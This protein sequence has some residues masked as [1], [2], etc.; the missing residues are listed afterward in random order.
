M[1]LPSARGPLSAAVLDALRTGTDPPAPPPPGSRVELETVAPVSDDDLQLAL[2]MPTSCTTAASTT[3]THDLRV[4]PRPAAA[5]AA[6]RGR[7][8]GRAPRRT[9]TSC[10][11]GRGGRRRRGRA[12]LR[13][14]RRRRRPAR[15]AGSCTA[16]PPREQFLEFLV[17]RSLYHLKESDPHSFVLPRLDGRRQGRARRAAVRRVRRRPARAAAR[18]PVRRRPRGRRP[19]PRRTAPTSTT[20]PR[21]A[22]RSTTRCRCSACTGGCAARGHGPPRGL[23]GDQLAALP[24]DRPAAAPARAPA[25]RSRLLR[26]ARRGRR[27]AR[28][29]RA[30]ATSAAGLVGQDPSLPSDVLF[31]AA[32]CL[33]PRR[34]G[35]RADARALAGRAR[36]ATPGRRWPR[37]RD[38]RVRPAVSLA[39][40]A[41]SRS[42]PAP[43]GRRWSAAPTRSATPTARSTGHPA[44]G[45]RLRLRQVPADALVR[46][47]PQGDP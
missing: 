37:E 7:V 27:R 24:P 23:R 31:G 6:A 13:A 46:Q 22:S 10:R 45:G 9:A 3:S 25:R 17:Q 32:A 18:R 16:R 28:A 33:L 41:T 4:G 5:A 43:T 1:L 29:A 26:R 30:C 19:G 39:P 36:C 8:R 21:H 40:A 20:S 34:A 44:G 2:W 42:P 47:H 15:C 11:P 35:R 38:P 14:R 12:A